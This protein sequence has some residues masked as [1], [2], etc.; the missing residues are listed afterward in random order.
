MSRIRECDVTRESRIKNKNKKKKSVVKVFESQL[1][2]LYLA[3]ICSLR[4]DYSTGSYSGL[5]I[6]IIITSIIIHTFLA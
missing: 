4:R 6:T 3:V 1:A 2:A 5:I